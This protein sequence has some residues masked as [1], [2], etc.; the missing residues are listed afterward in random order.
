VITK[1]I[2]FLMTS[3]IISSGIIVHLRT[4]HWKQ[5]WEDGVTSNGQTCSRLS[6]TQ[7]ASSARSSLYNNAIHPF[8]CVLWALWVLLSCCD[9]YPLG[10]Q[11]H[12]RWAFKV[13]PGETVSAWWVSPHRIH[14]K[15]TGLVWFIPFRPSLWPVCLQR[16]KDNHFSLHRDDP[17]RQQFDL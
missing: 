9:K 5:L 10:I 14:L 3:H 1:L 4:N 12:Q 7:Q 16:I 15:S 17:K 6:N 11:R 8:R 2:Q 13:D